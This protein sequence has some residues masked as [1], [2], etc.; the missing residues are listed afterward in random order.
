[1][2]YKCPKCDQTSEQA[3]DCQ[4]CSVPMNEEATLANEEA[5]PES[6]QSQESIDSE[7]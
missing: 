1:M 4:N 2:T 5:T 6:T 7:E 3:G